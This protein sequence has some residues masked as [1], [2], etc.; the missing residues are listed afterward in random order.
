M[1][2]SIPHIQINK[3]ANINA[4]FKKQFNTNQQLITVAK[5]NKDFKTFIDL[6]NKNNSSSTSD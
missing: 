3:I 4:K 5:Q 1:N 6:N 2:P